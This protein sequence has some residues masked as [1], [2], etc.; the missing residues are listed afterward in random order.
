MTRRAFGSSLLPLVILLA[1]PPL[2]AQPEDWPLVRAKTEAALK[3]IVQESDGVL[4]VCAVDLRSGERLAVNHDLVFPQASAIKVA[5]LMELERRIEAGSIDPR[6]TMPVRAADIAGGSGVLSSFEDG[7]SRLSLRDL[8]SVM[9]TASDNTATNMLIGK[10][11]MD[12]VNGMLAGLGLRETRLR[13]RMMDQQASLRGDENT[14]TPAEAARIMALLG[15]G[16]F[17]NAA[18]SARVLK[19]LAAGKTAGGIVRAAVPA[20]T[21]VA[22]KAGEISGVQTEWALVELP[23]RPY[24]VALMVKLAAPEAPSAPLDSAARIV[25]EYFFKLSRSTKYGTYGP[26]PGK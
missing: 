4:G 26:A 2:G 17:V 6:E 13:R 18:V 14:S 5:V 23:G 15:K 24:A 3:A 21:S 11:G 1:A 19:T 9:I 8:A 10:V 25:Q 22:W 20:G 7:A 16:E 12:E